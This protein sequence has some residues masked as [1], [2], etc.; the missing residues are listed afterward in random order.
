MDFQWT[1]PGICQW[2][3]SGVFRWIVICVRSGAKCR[4]FA[5]SHILP[6]SFR[7][8]GISHILP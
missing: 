5:I 3:L 6:L 7:D 8:N 4:K 1:F 2:T